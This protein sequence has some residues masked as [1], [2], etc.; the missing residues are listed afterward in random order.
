MDKI[1][2]NIFKVLQNLNELGGS[3]FVSELEKKDLAHSAIMRSVLWLKEN[4]CVKINE[5][6]EKRFVLTDRGL[7]SLKNG[8]PERNLLNE[9]KNKKSVKINQ[10]KLKDVG[11]ALAQA[12]KLGWI[13]IIKKGAEK[14]VELT[15]EGENKI[16]E[17]SKEEIVLEAIKNKKD[18]KDGVT[19][20][21]LLSRGLIKKVVKKDFRISVLP[22]GR[23]LLKKEVVKSVTLLEPKYLKNNAWKKINLRPY[24]VKAQVKPIYPGKKHI[25]TQVMEYIRKIWIEMGFKEMTGPILDINFWVFDALYQPQDHPA[26]DM[27]DTLF[28]KIPEK[29]KLPEKNLVEGVRKAHETGG[30]TGST[31]WQ[32]KWDSEFAKKCVLRTHTT[33]LSARTL[34]QLRKDIKKDNLPAKYFSIG[35]NFRNET[36]DWKHLIEFYQTDGIVVDENVNFRKFL[37]YL[38]RYFTKLGFPN[39]R[40]R[41]AYFPYTE[42]STEIEVLHPTHKK[43]L[44]LGGAGIFRPEVVKPLLGKDIPVLAWGPGFERILMMSYDFKDIRKLYENNLSDLRKIPLWGAKCLQ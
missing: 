20:H 4:K 40:F 24:N 10:L 36:L 5:S 12:K 16:N 43:W 35:R 28:M 22:K 29:G 19:I 34:Y 13:L 11:I 1:P 21:N 23:E 2:P 14:F 17:N 6:F 31:G 42:M 8:L 27:Q 37:F 39:V 38:K 44:E 26:R 30:N 32:Y 7:D 25:I 3:A 9:L 18:V 41:P 33:S 15:K